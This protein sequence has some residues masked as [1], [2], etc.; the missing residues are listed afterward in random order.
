MLTFIMWIVFSGQQISWKCLSVL[1]A[2]G[3]QLPEWPAVA[4][5]NCCSWL[6]H[7]YTATGM[8][9]EVGFTWFVGSIHYNMWLCVGKWFHMIHREIH[10]NIL[11]YKK[12]V[13]CDS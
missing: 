13:S 3:G 7:Q 8:C 12:L 5:G 9:G 1:C 4:Q 6:T 10:Y 2:P 11:M